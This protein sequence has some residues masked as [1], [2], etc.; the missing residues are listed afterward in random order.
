MHILGCLDVIRYQEKEIEYEKKKRTHEYVC[1]NWLNILIK[2]LNLN[3]MQSSLRPGSSCCCRICRLP[4]VIRLS[5]LSRDLTPSLLFPPSFENTVGLNCMESRHLYHY[6]V[7]SFPQAWEWVSERAS[8]Q[9]SAAEHA[10]K[11]SSAEQ[12]NEWAVWANEQ[13]VA[14]YSRLDSWLFRTIVE[15]KLLRATKI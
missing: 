15:T 7:I 14:Q 3:Q 1:T 4:S 13:T 2:W 11:A 10:I 8:K 5:L 6:I 9:I 12:G